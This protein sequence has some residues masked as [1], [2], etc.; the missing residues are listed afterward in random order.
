MAQTAVRVRAVRR[1][2]A[3]RIAEILATAFEVFSERG[4]DNTPVS[5]IAE[6]LGVVEGTIYKYFE[7][8]RDL[9][10]KVLV[11]WNRGMVEDYAQHLPGIK[12][13]RQRLRYVIWRH[14]QVIR[15]RPLLCRLMFSEVRAEYDHFQ[16][17]F[18]EQNRI[19]TKFL[20]SVLEEGVASGEFRNDLPLGLV[21]DMVFGCIERHSWN[22]L[23]GRGGLDV[24]TIADQ[25]I[26]IICDGILTPNR[27]AAVRG[28]SDRLAGLVDR[29]ERLLPPR[30][31]REKP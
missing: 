2:P 19:Y 29:L 24:E 17:A 16:S 10:M 22:Y 20:I 25:I 9:L 14:L 6:R 5:V 26:A 12:G 28:E 4:Y 3:E 18:Y 30:T 11:N 31:G 1:A 21:R 15:E 7:S 27:T 23:W 8:K 13:T